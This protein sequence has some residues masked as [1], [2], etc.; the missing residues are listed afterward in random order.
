MTDPI[1]TP[2]S[3]AADDTR[4]TWSV[5]S[6]RRIAELEDEVD[7]L[8]S[9]NEILLSVAAYFGNANVLPARPGIPGP[10][11]TER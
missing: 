8:R 9:A 7:E 6:E 10:P 5:P 3:P 1:R 11:A 4:H 2:D